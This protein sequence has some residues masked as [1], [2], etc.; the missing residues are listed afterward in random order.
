MNDSLIIETAIEEIETRTFGVTG[1][2]LKIHKIVYADSK[3]IVARVDRDKE[4]EAIVYFN[5]ID[6]KFFLAIGVGVKPNLSVRWIKTEPFHSVYF[7]ASSDRLS[8]TELSQL[9]KLKS[10]RG[11]N[12][13]DKKMPENGTDIVWRQ[14]TIDFEP[15]P[16]A[17][18][19]EDKLKKLL[20]YLEQDEEGVKKLINNAGGYILVYSSFHSGNTMIGG[21]HIDKDQIKRMGRLNLEIDFD[22]SADG[23]FFT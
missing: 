12:K 3:P 1:Q 13:G 4:D 21:H 11:R 2:F 22:I 9:T 8:L 5:I 15:N 19:F 23:N 20:D 6:E 14:S 16:E 7:R 18:E 10:T 17:D